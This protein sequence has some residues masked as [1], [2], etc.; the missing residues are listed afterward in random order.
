MSSISTPQRPA[1]SGEASAASSF[2]Q[3]SA[4]SE[5][6]SEAG[7]AREDRAEGADGAVAGKKQGGSGVIVSSVCGVLA[8]VVAAAVVTFFVLRRKSEAGSY[9]KD[10]EDPAQTI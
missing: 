4:H 2:A 6:V 5:S 7:K 8:L 10:E 9:K 3:P 1:S